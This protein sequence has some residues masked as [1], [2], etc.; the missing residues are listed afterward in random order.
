[1]CLGIPGQ[2]LRIWEADG[3]LMGEVDLVGE[4]KEVSL[5]F[6]PDIEVGEYTIV[7]LGSALQRIDEATALHTLE[8]FREMAEIHA[9][10]DGPPAP[11]Q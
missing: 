5:R 1:M 10:F 3:T 7:H 9:Q 2:V 11:G 6:V 8:L 4:L